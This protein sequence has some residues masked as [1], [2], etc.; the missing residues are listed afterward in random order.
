MCYR[1]SGVS[2]GGAAFACG[3]RDGGS[4]GCWGAGPSALAPEDEFEVVAAGLQE[5]CAVRVG[6]EIHCWGGNS[7]DGA[8]FPS[9]DDGMM[10]GLDE[11]LVEKP[12]G[13]APDRLLVESVPAGAFVTVGVGDGAACGVRESGGLVCWGPVGATWQPPGGRF[14]SVAVGVGAV[15]CG[16]RVDE[17]LACWGDASEVWAPPV[18]R[19]GS[20]DVGATYAC[21]L[22]VSGEAVCWGPDPVVGP[23]WVHE[24]GRWSPPE[25]VFVDMALNDDFACGVLAGGEV[26]CWGP[27]GRHDCADGR[28]ACFGWDGTPIPPGPFASVGVAQVRSGWYTGPPAVCGIRADGSLV[29]W[30]D[31]ARVPRAPSGAFVDVNGAGSCGVRAGGEAVCWRGS[32]EYV[33][34]DGVYTAMSGSE[35]FGCGLR[36]DGEITCW[37]PNT[38]GAASPPPGPFTAVAV[39]SASYLGCGLR[40]DGEAVCWDHN[41]GGQDDPPPGPFTAIRAE[42]NGAGA[43]ACGLRADATAECWGTRWALHRTTPAEQFT[44]PDFAADPRWRG[45]FPEGPL[46]SIEMSSF[47]YQACGI[48]PGGELVCWSPLWP[49]NAWTVGEFSRGVLG[50]STQPEILRESEQPEPPAVPEEPE[51]SEESDPVMTADP[52]A[53][54]C[55]RQFNADDVCPGGPE[56]LD[57]VHGDVAGGP[58]VALDSGVFETCGLRSDGTVDCWSNTPGS[59]QGQFTATAVGWLVAFGVRPDGT[60]ER[61]ML[62]LWDLYDAKPWTHLA[63]PPGRRFVAFDSGWRAS[64]GL[65][66]DGELLC[67]GDP[68]EV[69]EHGGP[70]TRVSVGGGTFYRRGPNF[71]VSMEGIGHVCAIRADGNLECWGNN[72]WEQTTL[73]ARLDISPYRDVAAGYAHTCAIGAAGEVVCWGDDRYDQLQSP[74]GAF[75]A[76]SAGFWHT[77]GLRLDGEIDCWGNGF[78]DFDQ[79]YNR[80]PPDRPAGPP[81]GPFTAVAAGFWHTCA[82]RPDGTATCWLSY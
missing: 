30:N 71:D 24:A 72:N 76:L 40:A 36:A 13:R 31:R 15:A 45:S 48:R 50:E 7:I 34:A 54:L 60:I 33:M 32:V 17:T 74:P 25:G 62:G 28:F 6:G 39:A 53:P 2:V 63:A 69:D 41:D 1:L 4:V 47:L 56:E 11:I 70:F 65:L 20:V 16:I 46:S 23:E 8:P 26:H 14:G 77:C 67:T 80:P 21:A 49:P 12:L 81:A 37:G 22:R 3:V 43:Y 35:G 42:W 68:P 51:E 75:G 52:E 73:A 82:L 19:F 61:W 44:L 58:Y 59:P 27:Q 55:E 79:S 66:D 57:W 38:S 9:P 5:M 64:C 29:C 78:A 10:V 18:G